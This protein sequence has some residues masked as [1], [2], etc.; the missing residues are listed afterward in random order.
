MSVLI[1]L[2]TA[3]VIATACVRDATATGGLNATGPM[4]WLGDIS[5]A[6]YLMQYR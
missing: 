1:L 6:F 2:P 3:A 5:Y 4:V